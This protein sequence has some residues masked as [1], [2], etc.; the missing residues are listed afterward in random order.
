MTWAVDR[1]ERKVAMM[2]KDMDYA[3]S[4]TVGRPATDREPITVRVSRKQRR[5]IDAKGLAAQCGRSEIVRQ[6]VQ[7]AMD[8]EEST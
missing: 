5:W 6:I 4:G 8:A 3:P 7:A 2:N 1:I